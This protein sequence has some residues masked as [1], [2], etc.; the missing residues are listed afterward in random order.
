MTGLQGA[1]KIMQEQ[2]PA[3]FYRLK[4]QFCKH[5]N[6]FEDRG[7]IVCE[8]C[9]KVLARAE[10]RFERDWDSEAKDEVVMKKVWKMDF[11]NASIVANVCWKASKWNVPFVYSMRIWE[12]LLKKKIDPMASFE[13]TGD[14][15]EAVVI[16]QPSPHEIA[17]AEDHKTSFQALA[18]MKSHI[19]AAE[20]IY[21]QAET[22]MIK[23]F[24]E[25]K[26]KSI[27]TEVGSFTLVTVDRKVY[28]EEIEMEAEAL[29]M[30]K[31][32]ADKTGD[33]TKKPGKPFIK[34]TQTK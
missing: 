16:Y 12:N 10:D 15:P 17:F 5:Q 31:L 2:N 1:L 30:L 26:V 21:A 34:F 18:D 7:D 22:E 8:D 9:P 6:T 20:G 33:Y 28:G 3:M 32:A 29:K 25:F 4:E 14:E 13:M 27:T 19:K 23:K 24:K 11:T